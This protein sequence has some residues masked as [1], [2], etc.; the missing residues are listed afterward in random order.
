MSV[1]YISQ[2]YFDGQLVSFYSHHMTFKSCKTEG[3]K[4]SHQHNPIQKNTS[5]CF[6]LAAYAPGILF[7]R[8]CPCSQ[9]GLTLWLL[10]EPSQMSSF[11]CHFASSSNS[12][13]CHFLS[14]PTRFFWAVLFLWCYSQ[15]WRR[16]STQKKTPPK[17]TKNIWNHFPSFHSLHSPYRKA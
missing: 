11:Y 6:F 10:H 4:R 14:H 9:R 15:I 2:A 1:Q 5:S 17:P 7:W 13:E 12:Y 3:S 8:D 16:S